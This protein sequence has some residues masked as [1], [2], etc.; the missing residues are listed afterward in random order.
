MPEFLVN[1]TTIPV[2]QLIIYIIAAAITGL[3]A[4]LLPAWLAGRMNV[5]DSISSGE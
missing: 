5:L 2:G 4:G 1:T 3:L